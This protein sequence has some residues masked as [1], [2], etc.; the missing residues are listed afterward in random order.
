MTRTPRSR[1]EALLLRGIDDYDTWPAAEKRSRHVDQGK[2]CTHWTNHRITCD[3]YD[4]MRARAAQRCEI[5]RKPEGEAY[6]DRLV[7]DHLDGSGIHIV[8]GMLCQYCNNTVMGCMDG[9]R[10]WGSQS[11]R[12]R[13]RA[14][15]YVANSWDLP[16]AAQWPTV[17][18]ELDARLRA[19]RYGAKV[20]A[21]LVDQ[22]SKSWAV[23]VAPP[24]V[25]KNLETK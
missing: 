10:S 17:I 16:S 12:L 14:L 4:D 23:L 6:F 25:A 8:R 7:V 18:S 3:E 2:L 19:R 22:Y 5:C 1:R 9:T 13:D 24:G 20:P 15:V 21:A 11:W